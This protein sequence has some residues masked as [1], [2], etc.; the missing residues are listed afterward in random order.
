MMVI[1]DLDETTSRTSSLLT[2]LIAWTRLQT[3]FVALNPKIINLY[4][5]ILVCTQLF[6]AN[7][8]RKRITIE[9]NAPEDIQAFVDE[10]TIQT[11]LRNLISNGI[12]FT[13]EGGTITIN[14][15]VNGQNCVISIKDSGVGMSEEVINKIFYKN[16]HHST[17]GTGKEQGSGLGLYFV[18]EFVEKNKGRIDVNS[19]VGV[20]T[21]IVLSLPYK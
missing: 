21:E 18:K 14:G 20:G 13:P 15:Q 7:A 17:L 16:E 4:D 19:K 10:A 6:M 2:N 5:L 9:L 12:K 1:K 3:D 11:V 8:N